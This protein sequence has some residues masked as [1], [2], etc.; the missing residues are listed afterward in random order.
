MKDLSSE[1]ITTIATLI[2]TEL[3]KCK[4]KKELEIIKAILLQII[5]TL[6]TI[7]CLDDK[8]LRERK[9]K[10]EKRRESDIFKKI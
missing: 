5:S 8:T 9:E 4:T 2:A 6:G 7:S 3:S 10:R 1:E